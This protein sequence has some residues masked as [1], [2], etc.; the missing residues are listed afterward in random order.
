ML[1]KEVREWIKKV[2]SKQY[3]YDDAISEFIRFSSFLTR[4]EMIFLKNP[5]TSSRRSTQAEMRNPSKRVTMPLSM[6]LKTFIIRLKA[7]TLPNP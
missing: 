2:E 3:S 5:Q 6:N 7:S 4:E 1:T